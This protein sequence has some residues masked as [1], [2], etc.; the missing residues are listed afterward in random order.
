MD[1]PVKTHEQKVDELIVQY[2]TPAEMKVYAADIGIDLGKLRAV[3]SMADKIV[4]LTATTAA[5]IAPDNEQPDE[6]IETP[7]PLDLSKLPATDQLK[8]ANPVET[9]EGTKDFS[10]PEALLAHHFVT[11]LVPEMKPTDVP[12][13]AHMAAGLS[14]YM[15]EKYFEDGYDISKLAYAGR[16]MS[17]GQPRG[18]SLAF[19]LERTNYP[20]T[21][22]IF[23]FGSLVGPQQF[24][25]NA[26]LSKKLADGY[27]VLM[28][29]IITQSE[30]YCMWVLVK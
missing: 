7:V 22:I 27:E 28:F 14:D 2:P 21:D 12:M 26:W 19:I 18:H 20:A 16:E 3:A 23:K 15:K 10:F 29:E 13:G 8:P 4:T 24:D 6:V 25:A 11:V 17:G 30:L 5:P 9:E 1:I